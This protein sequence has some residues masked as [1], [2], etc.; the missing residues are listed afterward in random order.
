MPETYLNP[1]FNHPAPDP[2]VFK[3]RGEFWCISSH[4]EPGARKFEMLRSP[5]LVRWQIVGGALDP[6]PEEHPYYWAPE[7]SY[8]EGVFY[9]Y[10]SVGNETLM[11]LRVATAAAPEGP[12]V[13]QGIRLTREDFAIDAHVFADEDGQ[14]WMFYAT[15]FLHH[16]R[17]GTGTVVDR[18]IDPRTLEGKPRPVSRARYDWQVFDPARASKGGVKWHTVEGSFAL[19]RKGRYYQMFSGGNWTNQSYGVAYAR[20][21]RI[22]RPDEW[23]QP[24]D[25]AAAPLVLRTLP[26]LVTGP[27]HNS[28]VRGPDNRQ[29]YCV[30]HR[31]VD[32]ARVLAIDPLDW[33]G[34][35]LIVLGPSHTPQPVPLAPAVRG[36]AAAR[37]EGGRWAAADLTARQTDTRRRAT[38]RWDARAPQFVFEVTGRAAGEPGGGAWGVDLLGER[39]GSATVAVR[40]AA[41]ALTVTTRGARAGFPLSAAFDATADHLLRVEVDGARVTLM[42]D[43]IAA[44]FQVKLPFEPYGV[45]LFTDG[46]AA[47]F[48]AP[49]LTPGWEELFDGPEPAPGDLDWDADEG[50]SIQQAELRAARTGREIVVAKATPGET[51]DLA[52]SIR[53]RAADEGGG[54]ALYPA[55]WADAPTAPASGPRLLIRKAGPDW[56]LEARDSAGR[57]VALA[58]PTAFDGAEWRQ[59]RF[60]VG[61]GRVTVAL[62]DHA[63]GELPLDEPVTHIALAAE[64]AEVAVDMVRVTSIGHL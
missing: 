31:W 37:L 7:I 36:F 12:Y 27:G 3:H 22:D 39:R 42:V 11:Q 25:G 58:L 33:A 10:Y 60:R 48:A 32:G 57:P 13:D 52:V 47:E 18:M 43:D 14:R 23:D 51:Y 9:L 29:L 45:A 62:E 5:D 34:D 61:G 17:I 24:C 38:A 2:F 16:E 8:L 59:W 50:W 19:K 53:A 41:R 26:G 6:L 56:R 4:C 21:D 55:G 54:Y 63:L 44:R 1:V 49:E 40:P 28:V 64:G 35:R 20:S 46:L 15:D 30:Y